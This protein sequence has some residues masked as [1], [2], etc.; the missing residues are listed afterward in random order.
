[1]IEQNGFGR[2]YKGPSCVGGQLVKIMM[3]MTTESVHGHEKK[4]E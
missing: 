1:M 2:R 4:D 3:L